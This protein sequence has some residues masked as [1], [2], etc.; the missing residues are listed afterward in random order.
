[1]ASAQTIRTLLGATTPWLQKKGS[2]SARLDAEL[3]IGHALGLQRLQLYLDLD[4]PLSDAEVD[5]C[6]G[7]VRRRGDGEPVAYIVGE[8]GFYG[9]LLSVNSAV[10]VPRPETELLVELC[11]AAIPAD[12]EGTFVD[13]GTGS[14]CIAVAILANRPLLRAVA[15]DI[16][17]AAIEVAHANAAKLGVADRFDGR[18]G[19]DG[20]PVHERDLVAIVS[21]PPYVVRGATDLAADVARY[22]PALALYGDGDGLDHHRRYLQDLLPRAAAGAFI[23]L[24]IGFDQGDAAKQLGVSAGVVDVVIHK[25]LG[26]HARVMSGRVGRS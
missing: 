18:V 24:E 16:S 1:M 12:V 14:G 5:R 19:A 10:L 21:N 17:A 11:L 13:I 6:R 7:L 8:Q 9:L 25:D 20:A 23:G 2:D 15:T 3:M 4:R 22:E 26:G